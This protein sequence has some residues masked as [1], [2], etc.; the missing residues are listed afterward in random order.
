MMVRTRDEFRSSTN[1]AVIRAIIGG[2]PV[3]RKSV[4]ITKVRLLT[5]APR[6]EP[7]MVEPE[8][9][10]VATG[11]TATAALAGRGAGPVK[12]VAEAPRSSTR[13][14][15]FTAGANL[16]LIALMVCGASWYQY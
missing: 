3:S 11:T 7:R 5:A 12:V 4:R 16:C 9:D 8:P 14:T 2:P 6:E 13:A 15:I 1:A 10:A